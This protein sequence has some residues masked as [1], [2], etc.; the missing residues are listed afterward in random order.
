MTKLI[1]TF[2]NYVIAPKKGIIRA[3]SYPVITV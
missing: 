3:E 2:C 1:G